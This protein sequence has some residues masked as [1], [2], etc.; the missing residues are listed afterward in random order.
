MQLPPNVSRVR[1]TSK[2]RGAVI[3]RGKKHYSPSFDH[4]EKASAW[5]KAFKK[6]ST[7][8][9]GVG[10]SLGD[11]VE[12]LRQDIHRKAL[13]KQTLSYYLHHSRPLLQH[14]GDHRSVGT[15]TSDHIER[16][17]AMRIQ[18][19]VSAATVVSKD[20]AVL[21]RL[22]ALA[23][24]EGLAF[25]D[26]FLRA[27]LPKWKQGRFGFFAWPKVLE[28]L[29]RIR[30]SGPKYRSRDRDADIIELVARTGL[31]Q[32]EVSRLRKHHCDLSTRRIEV[33][34]KTGIRYIPISSAVEEILGRMGKLRVFTPSL[35]TLE[36]ICP[37]WQKRLGEPKLSYH[38]LRHS[39]ATAMAP[40]VSSPFEL[41]AL[42]GHSSTKQTARYYH[43]TAQGT[44][45]ALDRL[46]QS[47][48]HT[49]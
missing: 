20:L 17:V 49:P 35:R 9:G 21:K 18:A 22:M 39:F 46:P 42:L 27:R 11:L 26:P 34:G 28:I 32:T 13:T 8:S 24:R 14:F 7:R 47:D 25:P 5:V 33:D 36:R 30:S 12:L 38:T 23:R 40:L 37:E 3:V 31:R 4:P 1:K 19:G 48:S 44:L 16:F 6:V 41:Q 29:E 10:L 2:F 45:A 43:A 15:I